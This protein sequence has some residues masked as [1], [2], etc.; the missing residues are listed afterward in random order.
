MTGTRGYPSA[1]G[2]LAAAAAA[3]V[4]TAAAAASGDGG[5]GGGD[6]PTLFCLHKLYPY[7]VGALGSIPSLA[8]PPV[9]KAGPPPSDA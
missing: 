8:W 1:A 9:E 2:P 6:T 7:S 5:G 3:V 4:A